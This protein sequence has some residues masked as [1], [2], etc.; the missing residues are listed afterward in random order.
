MTEHVSLRIEEHV[1]H[2]VLNRAEKY[3]AVNRGVIDGLLAAGEAL[4]EDRNVRAVVLSGAGDN[5]CAGIDL[6]MFQSAEPVFG[7]EA[8]KPQPGNIANYFQRAATIW[9]EV[10]VPVIAAL[11]GICYGAGL[12]IAFGADLRIAAPDC[13]LSV[14]EVKWGIVPDMGMTVTARGLLRPDQLKELALTGRVFDGQTALELGAVTRLDTAPLEAATAL[15]AQIASRSP[16]ATASIKAL[17]NDGL[18]LPPA[19]ALRLEAELQMALLGSANQAEA[20]AANLG[21][22]EPEFGPRKAG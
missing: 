9:Q 17:L 12:Q 20:V 11:H 10:P 1:A 15:A 21:R 22:R 19:E 13:K 14:M 4:T 3:N 6:A 5:F 16:D 7:P 2:V 8:L 18:T